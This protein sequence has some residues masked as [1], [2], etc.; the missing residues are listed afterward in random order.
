[1]ISSDLST[2]WLGLNESIKV[3]ER[4]LSHSG[5]PAT[6]DAPFPFIFGVTPNASGSQPSTSSV[7]AAPSWPSGPALFSFGIPPTAAAP[8]TQ[9]AQDSAPSTDQSAASKPLTSTPQVPALPKDQLSTQNKDSVDKQGAEVSKPAATPSGW[10]PLAMQSNQAATT[11]AAGAAAADAAKQT[12]A[13]THPEAVSAAAMAAAAPLAASGA[14]DCLHSSEQAAA[15]ATAAVFGAA[16]GDKPSGF[17]TLPAPMWGSNVMHTNQAA[18]SQATQA[19]A[20]AAKE[21]ESISQSAAES[22]APVACG[23]G[24]DFMH[25][26]QAA[27][28]L[29]THAA[30][31]AGNEDK[32]THTNLG[33]LPTIPSAWPA[34]RCASS[35]TS[36]MSNSSAI[37]LYSCHQLSRKLKLVYRRC[38]T[39]C[40]SSVMPAASFMQWGQ[41]NM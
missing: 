21:K 17:T 18:A 16:K 37:T 30:A 1:M 19:A 38:L 23:W 32:G 11:Q 14:N 2:F 34:F 28:A 22:A 35:N 20:D 25:T 9:L 5:Q 13:T 10:A 8:S 29:A 4:E 26:N 15:T 41:L 39:V 6:S 12:T 24:A 7:A 3:K 36:A 40:S 33:M 31:Q 27:A